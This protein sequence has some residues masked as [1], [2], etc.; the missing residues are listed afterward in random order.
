M[1]YIDGN[2]TYSM[3]RFDVERAE[4]NGATCICLNDT[5]TCEG[6]RRV[7]EWMRT[8]PDWDCL[9]V[10]FDAG[11]LIALKRQPKPPVSQGDF[12]EWDGR[13]RTSNESFPCGK[14]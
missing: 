10:N 5:V 2:H 4:K 14:D 12:D 11:L 1:A 9:E 6:A 8:D 3:S 7:G 13:R